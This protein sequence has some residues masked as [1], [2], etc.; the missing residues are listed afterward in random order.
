MITFRTGCKNNLQKFCPIYSWCRW[1]QTKPSDPNP[2]TRAW[3]QPPQMVPILNNMV[4]HSLGCQHPSASRGWN[5]GVDSGGSEV[6][7]EDLLQENQNVLNS[8]FKRNKSF[9]WG[10]YVGME[11]VLASD[12]LWQSQSPTCLTGLL[13]VLLASPETLTA[14]HKQL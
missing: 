7:P 6:Y 3:I 9:R 2:L 8:S 1:T 14:S 12:G 11:A 13:F 5:L 4:N 10:Q